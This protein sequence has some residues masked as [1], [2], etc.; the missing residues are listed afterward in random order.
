MRYLLLGYPPGEAVLLALHPDLYFLDRYFES[1]RYHSQAGLVRGLGHPR[2]FRSLQ[3]YATLLRVRGDREG[4]ERVAFL[5]DTISKLPE[6]GRTVRS[7]EAH[8]L[9]VSRFDREIR[10]CNRRAQLPETLIKAVIMQES[11]G[12]PGD[13]SRAGAMGLMQLMPETAADLG[14]DDP[15]DPRENI[16]GG[17]RYLKE[18]L[19]RFNWDINLALA[20]Y[21]AGP[22]KVVAYNGIPPY[23]ETRTYVR[24]VRWIKRY[25][26]SYARN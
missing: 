13:V 24:N 1:H 16:C 3:V 15:F 26:D 22:H 4:E 6:A 8:H 14:V 17:V 2:Y 5:L 11:T 23:R 19:D 9:R 25:L 21:N 20:A 18:M 7:L 10:E 12:N